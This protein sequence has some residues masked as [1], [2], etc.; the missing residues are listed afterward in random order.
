M[1]TL[2]PAIQVKNL[3]FYYSKT[4]AIDKVSLDIY[5]NQVTA[6]IGPS[7]CGKSTLIKSLNRIGELESSVKVEGRVEFFGQNIYDPRINLNRLRRQI[8]MVFQKPNPFPMSI[9]ENIAYG[10]RIAGKCSQTELDA[11]V[12]S[13]LKGAALWDEVKDKLNKSA[14]SL[15]GG[16]QQRLCIARALAVKPKVLLMDEPCSALDPIATM[17][18]EELIHSLRSELTIAI[19]THNMQQATRVSDFTAFF[20]TDE[21]RIG[22]MVE[23]GITHQIFNNALDSR[24]RDYVSGLF[25]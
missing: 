25:G 21:S 17:K 9:Y 23:F 13:A 18:I 6:L 7:G 20:S 3:S 15:S 19:V 12:E 8:G 16:Q 10:M 2:N 1:N 4:K 5:Q 24:T 11:V 22:Q 14:L